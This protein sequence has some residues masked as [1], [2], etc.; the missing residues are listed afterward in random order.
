FRILVNDIPRRVPLLFIR[1]TTV[2]ASMRRRR[3]FPPRFGPPCKKAEV[4]REACCLSV[5]TGAPSQT[6]RIITT[7]GCKIL[8]LLQGKPTWSDENATVPSVAAPGAKWYTA[9]E[10]RPF[11]MKGY[12]NLLN[13]TPHAE[14]S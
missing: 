14:G 5:P 9:E 8:L 13:H 11:L 1:R 12:G 3:S 2:C 10:C 4:G 6:V 7:D